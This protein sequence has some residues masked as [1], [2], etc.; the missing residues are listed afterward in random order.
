MMESEKNKVGTCPLCGGDVVKTCKGFKCVNNS[1][2]SPACNFIVPAIVCNRR[3]SDGEAID[4]IAGRK[5]LL[6]GFCSKELKQFSSVLTLDK[7]GNTFVDAKIGKC[8]RCCGDIYVGLRGFNC[9]NFKREEDPCKFTI[10]RYY[11]GHAVTLAEI[12]EILE[13]GGTS[14]PIKMYN[15]DGAVYEKHLGLSPDR[16]SVIKF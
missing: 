11:G 1:G 6:D 3:L 7:G 16:E 14:N 8:P 5:L 9:S 2:D 4:L 12:Y 10:W 13:K 15:E